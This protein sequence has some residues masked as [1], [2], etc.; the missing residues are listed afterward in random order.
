[1]DVECTLGRLP[2]VI[3]S[4][5]ALGQV[6]L[7]L[8]QNGMDAMSGLDR[9]KRKLQVS[10]RSTETHVVIAVRDH[11]TGIPLDVQKRMFDAF[12]T[13]K[14][15]GKGTGL[16]LAICKEIAEGLGGALT[17]TTGSDGTCFELAIPLDL[18][19]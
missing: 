11:G 19:D 18:T 15:P 2:E 3:G 6:T 1:M 16:G 4:P 7:N 13:T 9:K 14:D 8:M 17:F 12:F 10:G 5:S